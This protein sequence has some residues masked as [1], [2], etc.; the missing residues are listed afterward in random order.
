MMAISEDD[1]LT[2]LLCSRLCHDLISPLGAITNGLELMAEGDKATQADAMSLMGASARQGAARLSYFRL[3][4]GAGGT[5]TGTAFGIVRKAIDEY[6]EDRK[7]HIGWADPAP[8]ADAPLERYFRKLLLNLMLVAGECAQRNA[9]IS[10]TVFPEKPKLVIAITGVRAKLRDDVRTGFDPSLTPD[11]M[12]VR[13]V[14][15][16]NCRRLAGSMGLQLAVV[17]DGQTSVELT[18]A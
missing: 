5:E 13:N 8:S 17:E 6:F 10:A 3:A 15:A 16:W 12:T 4:L 2:E 18:V 7:L 14:I 1:R 11:D 9:A